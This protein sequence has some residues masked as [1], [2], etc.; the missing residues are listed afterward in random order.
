MGVNGYLCM[1]YTCYLDDSRDANQEKLFVLAGF[2]G[3]KD[4][5]SSL[6]KDWSAVLREKGIEYYKS[7]E[8]NHLTDQFAKY[9]TASYPPPSG[10]NATKIM[11]G[12]R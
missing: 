9:R 5:W 7:S 6:R 10:R 11:R 12:L 1:V 2:F 3:T 4:D 8:Y